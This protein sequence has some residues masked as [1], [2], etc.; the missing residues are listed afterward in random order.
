MYLIVVQSFAILGGSFILESTSLY[1]AL[2]ETRKNALKHNLPLLKY[3]KFAHYDSLKNNFLPL[4]LNL[5]I[6]CT[7]KSALKYLSSHV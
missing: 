7:G 5:K 1:I 2:N 6:F 3:S 4:V